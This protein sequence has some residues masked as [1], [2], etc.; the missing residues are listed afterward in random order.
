M[1]GEAEKNNNKTK[2]FNGRHRFFFPRKA[3]SLIFRL[4]GARDDPKNIFV[5]AGVQKGAGPRGRHQS[6]GEK[7]IFS[8]ILRKIKSNSLMSTKLQT[9]HCYARWYEKRRAMMSSEGL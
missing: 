6:T 1:C 8:S 7:T 5:Q 4:T 9:H 2:V 3:F